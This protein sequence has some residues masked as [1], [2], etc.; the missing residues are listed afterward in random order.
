[1]R[2]PKVYADMT[3][4]GEKRNRVAVQ[5]TRSYSEEDTSWME[6]V[7]TAIDCT[8]KVCV[9]PFSCD[10]RRLGEGVRE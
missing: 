7:P 2:K 4:F 10:V 5:T 8:K 9:L 6:S 3:V 1:M